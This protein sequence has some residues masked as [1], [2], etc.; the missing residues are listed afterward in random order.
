L[1]FYADDQ[2]SVAPVNYTVEYWNGTGWEKVKSVRETP[3]IPLANTRNTVS[4]T[5]VNASKVRVYFTNCGKGKYTALSE[6]EV[7]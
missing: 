5:P 1:F 6:M 3:I 2:K 4:F 7:Y